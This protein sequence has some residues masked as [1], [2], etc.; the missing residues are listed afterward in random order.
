MH[1]LPQQALHCLKHP[2]SPGQLTIM[3]PKHHSNVE[4]FIILSN[5]PEVAIL[6]YPLDS[7]FMFFTEPQEPLESSRGLFDPGLTSHGLRD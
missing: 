1:A 3:S 6:G 2:S 5:H 7:E 4:P